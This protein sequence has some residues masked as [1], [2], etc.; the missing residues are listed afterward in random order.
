MFK[1]AS[2]VARKNFKKF[3]YNG[4]FGMFISRIKHPKDEK[5]QKRLKEHYEEAYSFQKLWRLFLSHGQWKTFENN[6]EWEK[7]KAR[8]LD[9]MESKE[10]H[11]GIKSRISDSILDYFL[12]K[13]LSKEYKQK[14][15]DLYQKR[16]DIE[17]LEGF[18]KQYIQINK[19][20]PVLKTAFIMWMN[21]YLRNN[22][23]VEILELDSFEL[24]LKMGDI[25]NNLAIEEKCKWQQLANEDKFVAR[26]K[27]PSERHNVKNYKNKDI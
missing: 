27:N 2:T 3:K 10:C 24:A 19:P 8:F 25:W 13:S 5:V 18:S 17:F 11:L 22:V 26:K 20:N 12:F 21:H 16:F 4:P 1:K 23:S 15:I 6:Q 14:Y 7:N 9:M